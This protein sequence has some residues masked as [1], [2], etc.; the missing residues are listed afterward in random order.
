MEN[1][2][3]SGVTG[4]A[5]WPAILEICKMLPAFF[6][7]RKWDIAS[8][9]VRIG[10]IRLMSSSLYRPLCTPSALTFCPGGCQKFDHA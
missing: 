2:L 6:F 10:C 4:F 8:C 7:S 9:V 5:T 3:T 1:R